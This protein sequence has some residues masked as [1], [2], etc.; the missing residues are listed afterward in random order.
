MDHLDFD[1]QQQQQQQQQQ[2]RSPGPMGPSRL[3]LSKPVIA[4]IR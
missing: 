3:L 2:L 4:A 1:L